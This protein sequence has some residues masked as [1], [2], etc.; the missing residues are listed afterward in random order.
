MYISNQTETSGFSLIGY[1]AFQLYYEKEA[2]AISGICLEVDTTTAG[3]GGK[4]EAYIKRI[5]FLE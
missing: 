4:A 5:E 3:G 1:S 2:P